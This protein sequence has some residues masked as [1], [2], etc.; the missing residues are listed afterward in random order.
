MMSALINMCFGITLNNELPV[1]LKHHHNTYCIPYRQFLPSGSKLK[2]SES[3]LL[4]QH[5]A[6]GLHF[7]GGEGYDD[8]R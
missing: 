5:D 3:E 6:L 2:A 4:M 7:P 1:T 8:K